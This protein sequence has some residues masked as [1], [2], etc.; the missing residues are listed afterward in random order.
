MYAIQI[1]ATLPLEDANSE[2]GMYD[3]VLICFWAGNRIHGI[4][5]AADSRKLPIANYL[6]KLH[7]FG[8]EQHVNS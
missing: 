3:G 5:E 7:E 2:D 6:V 1:D 8:S 4:V